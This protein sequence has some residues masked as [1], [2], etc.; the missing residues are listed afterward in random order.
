MYALDIV[1]ADDER[2]EVM[3]RSVAASEGPPMPWVVF[4]GVERAL[5]V[6][7]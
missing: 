2:G 7:E 6:E 4:R 3:E 1:E 5:A